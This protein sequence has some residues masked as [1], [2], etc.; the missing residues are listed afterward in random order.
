MPPSIHKVIREALQ[1]FNA[2]PTVTELR[3]ATHDRLLPY[4]KAEEIR[5]EVFT[6]LATNR[7]KVTE[8]RRIT[9]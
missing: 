8:D 4:Y 6:L 5:D 3:Y 2:P 7:L 1:A 9:F